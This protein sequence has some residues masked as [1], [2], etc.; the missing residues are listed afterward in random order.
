MT[1]IPISEFESET[2][3]N[4]LGRKKSKKTTTSSAKSREL[5]RRRRCADGRPYRR[6][7][8]SMARSVAE[9]ISGDVCE[10]SARL[11]VLCK[12]AKKKG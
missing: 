2:V 12:R 10:P 9:A 11:A 8:H 7:N 1:P 5:R 3:A 4:Y 6:S